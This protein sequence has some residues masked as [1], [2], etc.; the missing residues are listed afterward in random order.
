MQLQNYTHLAAHNSTAYR[1]AP[2]ICCGP[3]ASAIAAPDTFLHCASPVTVTVSTKLRTSPEALFQCC[4]YVSLLLLLLIHLHIFVFVLG[5]FTFPFTCLC[6]LI[7]YLHCCF[8]VVPLV[9][10]Y[11]FVSVCSCEEKAIHCIANI[12]SVLHRKRETG[13]LDDDEWVHA[14]QLQ[15]IK[16]ANFNFLCALI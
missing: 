7:I 12:L 10:I 9:L 8:F 13:K 11:F 15:Q 14:R 2:L 5:S 4:I 6:I 1:C 3:L 16:E